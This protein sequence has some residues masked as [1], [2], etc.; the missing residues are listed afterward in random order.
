M[1]KLYYIIFFRFI[2]NHLAQTVLR[3]SS[4]ADHLTQIILR[5]PSYADYLAQTVIRKSACAE[6]Q[7]HFI[8]SN[9]QLVGTDNIIL[10]HI[11]KQVCRKL[12]DR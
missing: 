4:C 9:L 10:L 5:R 2:L 11:Y 7:T 3:R 8:D 1:G 6:Q 12:S